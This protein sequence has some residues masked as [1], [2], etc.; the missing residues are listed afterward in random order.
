MDKVSIVTVTFNCKKTLEVTIQSVLNQLYN[1]I[2]YVIIDGGSTDG[3]VDIIKKYGAFLSYW[4]S[5]KDNGIFDAMNKALDIVKG[6]WVCFM[7]AGDLFYNNKVVNEIF[8]N[9]NFSEYD[10][11]YGDDA[12]SYNNGKIKINKTTFPFYLSKKRFKSMGFNH[13]STFVRTKLAKELRFDLSYKI[14]ADYNMIYQLY[15]KKNKKL[16]YTNSPVSIVDINGFSAQNR[17]Q[18]RFEEAKICGCEKN[19]KFRIWT[20]Y[21]SIRTYTKKCLKHIL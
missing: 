21:K 13:Q 5:E 8:N 1:N 10:C 6:E 7:N 14:S 4:H 15:Y 17:K 16:F 2:D 9:H 18:Q 20:L 12:Y 19:L 3:T 11:I